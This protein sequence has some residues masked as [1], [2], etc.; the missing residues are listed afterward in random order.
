MGKSL[1]AASFVAIAVALAASFA[2]PKNE[3]SIEKLG[4][5]QLMAEGVQV[6]WR[7]REQMKSWTSNTYYNDG[8]AGKLAG[9]T[10]IITGATRGL[11]R[12]IAAHMAALGAHLVLPC[13]DV[14]STLI[15]QIEEDASKVR[16]QYGGPQS[17][18]SVTAI[19]MDLS[20][21][22]SIEQAVAQMEAKGLSANIVINNAGLQSPNFSLSR[23]GF[24]T[25][26][27]VNFLGTAMFTELLLEK[28]LINFK[29][30]KPRIISISSEEHRSSI[31]LNETKDAFGIPW[32]SGMVDTLDRY[33][34]SK[35]AQ[36]TYFTELGR[37]LGDRAEVFDMCPG[38]V[39]SDIA[40]S[41][42]W[43]IGDLV[44]WL[45]ALTFQ[46][47]EEAALPVLRL[48][49]SP[50]YSGST[51]LHFHMAE[52]R[53]ARHD[54]TDIIFGEQIYH[55]T[56]ALIKNRSPPVPKD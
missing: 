22:D 52:E 9:Q 40:R 53:P 41:A 33:A 42:P 38:P 39:A 37:K 56:L 48:A 7:N 28:Q 51:S 50:E 44:V 30:S 15:Q 18:F 55:K 31:R 19:Q 3:G 29:H 12:G 2:F 4:T 25:T 24:E 17:S 11:G 27:A 5:V 34:Y 1:W 20:D 36:V 8:K 21:F 16:S 35:L 54:A 14:P 6:L 46:E 13:R 26:F 47:I 10:V 32:G 43:P 45:M 49:I 23:Q